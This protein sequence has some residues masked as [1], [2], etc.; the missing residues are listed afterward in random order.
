MAN[1]EP[2]P[3]RHDLG[4]TLHN[5]PLP[6]TFDSVTERLD[7]TAPF[8][9][10][11]F[12]GTPD[13]VSTGPDSSPHATLQVLCPEEPNSPPIRPAFSDAPPDCR[14]PTGADREPVLFNPDSS[15]DQLSTATVALIPSLTLPRTCTLVADSTSLDS[16]ESTEE[17]RHGTPLTATSSEED[18]SDYLL[19]AS[20]IVRQADGQAGPYSD[21][22]SRLTPQTI[23]RSI[24][25]ITKVPTPTVED[26]AIQ[27]IEESISPA[28]ENLI[29]SANEAPNPVLTYEPIALVVEGS[30][31]PI[32]EELTIP[33][34]TPTVPQPAQQTH[35]P[36]D[37][38]S[39]VQRS[40]ISNASIQRL[41][42]VVPQLT[43]QPVEQPIPSTTEQSIPSI[44]EK[45]I[46][47]TVEEL[48]LS[49][50]E[51]QVIKDFVSPAVEESILPVV[52]EPGKMVDKPTNPS[53]TV[54]PNPRVTEGSNV[55]D[56]SITPG[57]I[58]AT[59]SLTCQEQDE[60][61]ELIVD[62]ILTIPPDLDSSSHLSRNVTERSETPA[63]QKGDENPV[64]IP[65]AQEAITAGPTCIGPGSTPEL[66]SSAMD[67]PTLTA[68]MAQ[69]NATRSQETL[70]LAPSRRPREADE[71]T[72]RVPLSTEPTGQ[73]PESRTVL[74]TRC[75]REDTNVAGLGSRAFPWR[76]YH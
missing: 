66:S 45:S 57:L 69:P 9:S 12:Q 55:V 8:D 26:P 58:Q 48:I 13:A 19:G 63:L 44:A 27:P 6:V 76:V 22:V 52:E 36:Q 67:A 70:T 24:P 34:V 35:T 64:H 7:A 49:V 1:R 56:T 50:H 23:E 61:D 30:V 71:V 40:K 10:A 46:L 51:D 29:A 41:Q 38:F 33:V 4:P 39:S 14:E 18:I 54:K 59:T 28:T 73:P 3:P 16:P 53:A 2:T 20:C 31:T 47:P 62:A 72:I 32:V 37:L 74:E 60:A 15:A 11:P 42:T 17:L 68:P 25:P 75:R 65:A 5:T 43:V 21:S